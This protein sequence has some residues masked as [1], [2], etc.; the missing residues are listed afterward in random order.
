MLFHLA[1][2]ASASSLFPSFPKGEGIGDCYQVSQ[3]VSVDSCKSDLTRENLSSTFS[4]MYVRRRY[5]ES[6]FKC[7]TSSRK[8]YWDDTKI[9]SFNPVED[10]FYSCGPISVKAKRYGSTGSS[11][12]YVKD[13]SGYYHR[14]DRVFAGQSFT[15]VNADGGGVLGYRDESYIAN[16]MD[17][18]SIEFV[19]RWVIRKVTFDF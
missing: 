1:L 9:P 2:Y 16:V 8:K 14:A 13:S 7:D 4:G 17:S 6:L 12:Y 11:D 18:L 3:S 15:C 10:I 5:G 19:E